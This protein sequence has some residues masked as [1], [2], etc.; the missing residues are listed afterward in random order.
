V[1]DIRHSESDAVFVAYRAAVA[2]ALMV[3]LTDILNPIYAKYPDL[4][5]PGW[6]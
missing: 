4:K 3:M 2:D 1:Y 6:V 5:P